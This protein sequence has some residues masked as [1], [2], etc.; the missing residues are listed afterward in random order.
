MGFARSLPSIHHADNI[1]VRMNETVTRQ[2]AAT[3]SG[4]L[5]GAGQ[6]IVHIVLGWRVLRPGF[7]QVTNVNVNWLFTNLLT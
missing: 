1:A 3:S 7:P 6:S 2:L 5:T 4:H